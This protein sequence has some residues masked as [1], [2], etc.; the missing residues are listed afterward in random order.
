MRKINVDAIRDQIKKLAMEA[1]TELGAD[2]VQAIERAVKKEK[3]ASGKEILRLL[4]ENAK[5]AHRE[6]MPVCQDTGMAVVFCE[7]GQS[8]QIVGGPLDEAI[9]EGVRRGYEEGYLRKSVCDPVSRK[10]TSDN[11]PAVVHYDIVPG[12]RIHLLFAPKGFGAENMSRLK[13]LTPSQGLDTA[14]QFVVETVKNA[15][16]NPCPPTIIGVG[17][18]GTMEKSALMAKRALFRPLGSKNK[19]ARLEKLEKVWLEEINSLGIGPQ[20]LGGSITSLAVHID[21]FPTHIASLP[22]AVNIQCHAARHRSIEI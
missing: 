16:A 8:V 7:V 12:E 1:C 6:K 17:L 19:N 10:N 11:T 5:I 4:I 14:K 20:G 18:G 3:S 15:D 22:V 9:N 13:M 21:A 2:V